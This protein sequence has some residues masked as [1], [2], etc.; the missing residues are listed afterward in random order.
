MCYRRVGR[1]AVL[2]LCMNFCKVLS[3][4][5]NIS[6]LLTLTLTF[7]VYLNTTSALILKDTVVPKP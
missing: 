4:L 2:Q 7:V 3:F 5:M 1:F 6:E